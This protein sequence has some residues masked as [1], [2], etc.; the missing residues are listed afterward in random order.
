MLAE[1]I[2]WL[3]TSCP[4]TARRYGYLREAIGIAAR[5]QRCRADWKTH[6]ANSRTALIDSLAQCRDF[7]IALVLGSGL[8]LDVPLA[9]LAARFREV[10]LVDLVHLPAARRAARAYPNVKCIE[11]DIGGGLD[12]L[13]RVAADRLDSL[14]D[15][16]LPFCDQGEIDWVA[17]VN[18]LSQLPL[19][20]QATLRRRF[21]EMDEDLLEGWGD[22]LMRRHLDYLAGFSTPVCLLAD[23]EQITYAANGEVFDTLEYRQR[24][25]LTA[26]IQASWRWDIAPPGEIAP[27]VGRFHRVAAFQL[28]S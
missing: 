12:R 18:L 26:P 1:W 23:I 11:A 20:P 17:S 3:T 24:L 15:G 4:T 7:R 10:W 16:P 13:A 28:G 6:L 27:G 19:L 25:G 9:Q 22:R 2:T 21:P 5:H 8:L 14:L